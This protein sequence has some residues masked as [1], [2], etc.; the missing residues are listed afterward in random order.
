M[1]S[2]YIYLTVL[3]LG[4][5][6]CESIVDVKVNETDP[7]LVVDAWLTRSPEPQTIRLT[8]TQPYY[9]NELASGVTGAEVIITDSYGNEFVFESDGSGNY[10]YT[11]TDTFGVVGNSY[12][13]T[14]TYDGHDYT[15]S[16]VLPRGTAIDSI[17]FTYEK[18]VFEGE[19]FYSQFF[20]RDPIGEGDT[21]WL[22]AWKNGQ[23]LNRP[24]ELFYFYD[25]SFSEGNGDGIPFIFPLRVLANPYEQDINGNAFPYFWPA[26]TFKINPDNNK[27]TLFDSEGEVKD[28]KIEFTL[29]ETRKNPASGGLSSIPLDGNPYSLV[30]DTMVVKGMD[31]L[32]LELHTVSNDAWFFLYRLQQE[33]DRPEG[34]GALFA[35]PP[36]NLPTNITCDD[37]DIPV[38][39]FFDISNVSS[40]G[41]KFT[42]E[43]TRYDE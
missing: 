31:S 23:Y 7:Y 10:I 33:T 24:S 26:D 29:D 38:V 20:G 16:T 41:Q 30:G 8:T 15:S 6:S 19:Y 42:P 27:V 36:A 3:V 35:T 4:L 32:Y 14:V 13:L 18:N 28:G 5:I 9:D 11:P 39:G 22:K 43:V 12:F 17:N 40:L 34:F 1:K 25:A 21:Y 37:P 2:I